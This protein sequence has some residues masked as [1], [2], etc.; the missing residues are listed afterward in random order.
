MDEPDQGTNKKSLKRASSSD[1]VKEHGDEREKQRKCSSSE[2]LLQISDCG[3]DRKNNPMESDQDRGSPF[4]FRREHSRQQ[5]GDDSVTGMLAELKQQSDWI[6][7]S[8]REIAK[9]GD[10]HLPD[11]PLPL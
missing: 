10:V 4:V 3:E 7:T 6:M 9:A 11:Y 2:G 8:I 5:V 1:G